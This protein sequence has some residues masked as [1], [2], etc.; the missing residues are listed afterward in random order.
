MR[1]AMKSAVSK[2]KHAIMDKTDNG[3]AEI[4][5][6]DLKREYGGGHNNDD[7][8]GDYDYD[9]DD[10]DNEKRGDGNNN[11][12]NNKGAAVRG[13]LIYCGVHFTLAIGVFVIL[14]I[15]LAYS[16]DECPVNLTT[17]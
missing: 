7:D 11:N 3:G 1:I 16:R 17:I 12:N 14:N 8:G 2:V 9:D 15:W 5:E 6:E 13:G 4:E 10:D